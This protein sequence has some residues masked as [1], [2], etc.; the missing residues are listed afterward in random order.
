MYGVVGLFRSLGDRLP[1][2]TMPKSAL[3][4]TLRHRCA[5]TMDAPLTNDTGSSPAETEAA[6]IVRRQRAQVQEFVAQHRRRLDRIQSELADQVA[7]LTGQ[8]DGRQQE[9]QAWQGQLDEQRSLVAQRDADLAKLQIELDQRQQEWEAARAAFDL[10]NDELNQLLTQRQA[11]LTTLQEQ[12]DRGS[13][14]VQQ[15]QRALA[16]EREELALEKDDLL[17]QRKRL[18]ERRGELDGRQESLEDQEIRT[19]GQRRR[20]ARELQE[21]RQQLHQERSDVQ[22]QQRQ[23]DRRGEELAEEIAELQTQLGQVTEQLHQAQETACQ[24]TSHDADAAQLH[25]TERRYE[26]AMEEIHQQRARISQ[27]EQELVDAKQHPAKDDKKP[28]A[29]DNSMDWESQKRRMLATLEDL[30]ANDPAAASK[31]TSVNDLV[32]RTDLIVAERDR[33]IAELRAHLEQQSANLGN[34]AVGAA[35][36]AH[37]LDSDDFIRQERENLQELQRE[38]QE[39]L[40]QAEVDLSLERAK[41]ARERVAIEEK[42]V[43]LEK[44]QAQSASD[45]PGS[46]STADNKPVRGRWLARLGLKEEDY[47]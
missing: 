10:R 20:I 4:T 26:L 42:L 33:E 37:M 8:L 3:R 28:L 6:Q 5:R 7:R 19:K 44:A 47:K 15:A 32:R 35:A 38:W 27:L 13:F 21:Q 9:A 16:A 24:G 18:E 41:I 30:D 40:R 31:R 36:I 34:V 45:A 43:T 22:A 1:T 12:I 39:K 17:R 25:E 11:E 29:A 14:Q 2:G 23:R 46:S